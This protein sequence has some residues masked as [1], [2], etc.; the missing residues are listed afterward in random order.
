MPAGGP[1]PRTSTVVVSRH[2]PQHL[3]LCLAALAR[4]THPDHEIVLVADPGSV[5]IR[6]DLPLKRQ[7]FDI[8]SVGR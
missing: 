5:G 2:R 8:R 1:P 7:V 6:P 3:A 4:Q